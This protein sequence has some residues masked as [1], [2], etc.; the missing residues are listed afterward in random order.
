MSTNK[1]SI[2]PS[3]IAAL[4][5]VLGTVCVTA[6]TL[7]F[8]YFAPHQQQP[9]AIV[10]PTWTIA[11]TATIANTPVPTD[12]VPVGEPT[13]TAAPDTPTPEPVLRPP[14]LRLARIGQMA[15]SACYGN[16][17]QIRF[18]QPPTMVVW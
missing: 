13:S 15:A 5:G 7:Y 16:L 18:K 9:T 14:R 10:Q 8:S 1:R 3:I 6:V 2:D 12:T 11:P 4:I 17:I